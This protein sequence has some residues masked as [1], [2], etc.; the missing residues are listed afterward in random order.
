VDHLAKEAVN[1]KRVIGVW[2]PT[3][4]TSSTNSRK[5][6]AARKYWVECVKQKQNKMNLL[7]SVFFRSELK[8]SFL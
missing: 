7:T 6:N 1:E 8:I 2:N 5:E 4:A 3:T